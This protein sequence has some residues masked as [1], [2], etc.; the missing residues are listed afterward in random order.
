MKIMTGKA[1]LA[2]INIVVFIL[3]TLVCCQAVY[4]DVKV[5]GQTVLFFNPPNHPPTH[6]HTLYGC[7]LYNQ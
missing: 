6:L 3:S 2:L 5:E 4:S 1:D 7:T